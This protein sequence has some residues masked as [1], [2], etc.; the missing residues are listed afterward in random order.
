MSQNHYHVLGVAPTAA[1]AE[2]KRAY[3]Q[4]VV[5][6]HPDKH[7][8]DVRY[9]EQFRAV[10]V[11]YGVLGAPGKRASY[12]HQLAQATRRAQEAQ[13]QQ[14][15]RRRRNAAHKAPWPAGCKRYRHLM[16]AGWPT[17]SRPAP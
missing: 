9:E 2:I 15:Y 3:R 4:L 8:G 17:P 1:A 12:D 13:R 10:A 16:A 7:G 14:Q 6:Y 5:R 11:A